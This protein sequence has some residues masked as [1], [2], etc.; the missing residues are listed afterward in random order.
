MAEVLSL[1]PSNLLID[2]EN[3]RLPQPN[4]GQREALRAMAS[5]Q[6]K[7]LVTL[8]KDI[9]EYGLNPSDLPIVMPANDD[10]KRY[11][12][13]EGNRRLVALRALENPDVLVGAL[14]ATNLTELRKLSKKYQ[15]SP[16]DLV[17]CLSVKDKEEAQ[18]W[19]TLRHTGQNEGAGIVPWGSDEAGRFRARSGSKEIHTQALDFLEGRGNLTPSQRSEV[20]A[21][22][23]KRLLGTPEV[24]EKVGLDLEDGHL[25]VVGD[26][27]KVAKALSFIVDALK[28]KKLK[29][30]DI[31]S[32]EQRVA[33][34]EKLPKSIV[35]KAQ[36][37]AGRSVTGSKKA[38]AST[39]AKSKNKKNT[40]VRPRDYL[41]PRNCVLSISDARISKI[42]EELRSLSLD[43]HTNAVSVLCRVFLELSADAYIAS[44]TVAATEN[45]VLAKKFSAVADDLV[46]RQKLTKQQAAPVRRACQKDSFLAP[47][48]SLMHQY[49]HNRH[50]FP[51]AG[52]LRAHWDSLQPFVVAMWSP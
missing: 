48:I 13:L 40:P 15:A 39:P 10:L 43:N 26:E 49:V 25:Q 19:I 8:A 37:K 16:I 9:I 32:Q 2:A 38:G 42:E 17:T 18:H 29:T 4:E 3:P 31:Y 21:A 44:K 52:D 11:F 27:A 6:Q 7:K 20:P 22:T 41:I 12:V 30:K 5:H 23:F 45:D 24:R 34:A 51:A 50:L 46:A 14:D 28:S 35:V 1:L 33:W 47:S 36:K